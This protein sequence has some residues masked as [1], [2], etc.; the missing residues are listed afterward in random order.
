MRVKESQTPMTS[1][2]PA[3]A[4]SPAVAV[5]VVS[6]VQFLTPFMMSAVGV[7]LPAIGREFSAGAVQLG[8]VEMVYILAVALIMLPAG[9][10]ADIHGRKKIFVSGTLLFIVATLL[11]ALA[12][13]ITAFI[14]FRFLQGTGAAMVTATSVAILSSIVPPAQRGR[15]MGIVVA[16]VYV[17]LSA[18]PTL[19]G[20]MVTH[21]GWRWIFFFALPVELFAL[22]LTLT[23]LHG[24]WRGAQGKAFD[25]IGSLIYMAALFAMIYGATHLKEG[26]LPAGLLVAGLLGMIGFLVWESR[27]ASPI[28]NVQLLLE[29]RVFAMS[30]AATLINYA[31]SFGVTFF[32]SLYL[33]QVKGLSPQGAGLILITQ[34]LLQAA[35]SPLSGK[36]SD[37][38]PAARIATFG[39]AL[40]TVALALCTT[41]RVDTSIPVILSILVLLGIGFAFFSSPNMTTVMGSVTPKDYGIAS[42]LIA[43]MR[44][45]GMLTA[46]TIIT[47]ILTLFM[48]DAPV[49][50]ETA[51]SYVHAMAT[52][53]LIF[54][55]LSVLGIACSMGRMAKEKPDPALLTPID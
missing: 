9:R 13:T 25:W 14:L 44:T 2:P 47:I 43:T 4:V 8:L 32:F 1:P 22:F 11:L 55:A 41:I 17:G 10:M 28:L 16:A 20:F 50:A 6:A 7:A 54:T 23:R 3:P 45:V 12:P 18:G 31:A 33:Q 26:A 5:F 36:L 21:L 15:A 42:S 51:V 38:L 24:E 37:T 40:C 46:M 53:F 30:N 48:G 52:G 19:A 35:L 49:S 29:N 39:M 27:C 34:P